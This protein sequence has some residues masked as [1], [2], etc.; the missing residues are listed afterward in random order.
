[1]QELN[2]EIN[3]LKR[4]LAIMPKLEDVP[5]PVTRSMI[6]ANIK[7]LQH[8]LSE[9][10]KERDEAIAAGALCHLSETKPKNRFQS[11]ISLLN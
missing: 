11:I 1:M 10:E 9:L 3:S 7:N 8:E 6:D 4:R 5:N 2:N